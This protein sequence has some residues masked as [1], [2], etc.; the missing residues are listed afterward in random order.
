M[1]LIQ[2]IVQA[3]LQH[4]QLLQHT[5]PQL[6]AQQHFFGSKKILYTIKF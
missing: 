4:E 3:E 2:R 1:D 5:S 6:Q